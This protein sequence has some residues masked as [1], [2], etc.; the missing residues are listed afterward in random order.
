MR[1]PLRD[2]EFPEMPSLLGFM[3][4]ALGGA[5]V[6]VAVALMGINSLQ[7]KSCYDTGRVYGVN[8]DFGFFTN[9][10]VM[11]GNG[12]FVTTMDKYQSTFVTVT[13]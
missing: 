12:K 10:N 4:Y 1:N 3:V 9:C 6:F 2:K 7:A 8:V 11:D 13:K 5:F